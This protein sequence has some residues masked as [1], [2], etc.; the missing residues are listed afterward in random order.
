MVARIVPLV[1]L[2]GVLALGAG[3][4]EAPPGGPPRGPGPGAARPPKPVTDRTAGAMRV[5]MDAILETR[6]RFDG[7]K[8]DN[9]PGSQLRMRVRVVGE[10]CNRIVRAGALLIDEMLDD[11]GTALFDPAT[12]TDLMRTNTSPVNISADDLMGGLPLMIEAA[13]PGR[14]ARAMK[15]LTGKVNLLLA[16]GTT[17]IAIPNPR[18]FEGRELDDPRLKASGIVM[19]IV[20]AAQDAE[21]KGGQKSIGLQ[22]VE[23]QDAYVSAALT[24]A[25]MRNMNSR[26][27]ERKTKDDKP[28]F[29][30]TLATGEIN[31]SSFLAIKIYT[32]VARR[33]IDAKIEDVALP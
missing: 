14:D 24:D 11:R 31:P 10:G 21:D 9:A 27:V 1:V 6:I 5:E 29:Q 28:Y 15:R 19:R 32:N 18:Q 25:D 2:V 20:G 3:W 30:H 22:I 13:C 17:W 4:Q 8:P 26:F 7:E 16:D 12:I 33:T 23:G